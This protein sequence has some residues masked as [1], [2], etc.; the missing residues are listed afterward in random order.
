MDFFLLVDFQVF[1]SEHLDLFSMS[2]FVFVNQNV[3]NLGKVFLVALNY[4]TGSS[5]F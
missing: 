4:L 3:E 1:L 5:L 2:C